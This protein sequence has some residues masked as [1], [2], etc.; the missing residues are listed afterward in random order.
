MAQLLNKIRIW[1]ERMLGEMMK[2]D[3]EGTGKSLCEGME[4]GGNG[5]TE[6]QREVCAFIVRNLLKIKELSGGQCESGNADK[7]MEEYVYCA[8]INMWIYE[9]R[10]V[11]CETENVITNAFGAMEKV[12][13][14]FGARTQCEECAYKIME[15]MNMGHMDMLGVIRAAMEVKEKI[16]A[17][18]KKKPEKPCPKQKNALSALVPSSDSDMGTTAHPQ[19]QQHQQTGEG[20]A[21]P[22]T[23][24]VTTT[25]TTTRPYQFLT[26]LLERWIIARGMNDVEDF[27]KLIWQDLRIAFDDMMNNVLEDANDEKTMCARVGPDGKQMLNRDNDS[28]E[29]CKMLMKISM[30]IDGWEQKF[31][32]KKRWHWVPR[33]REKKAKERRLQNYLRCLIGKVTM[34]GMFKTHCKL[35][36]VAPVIKSNMDEKRKEGK[37]KNRSGICDEIDN[38]SLGVG[39]KLIWEELDKWINGY[40]RQAN[41]AKGFREVEAGKSP[42][43]TIKGQGKRGCLTGKEKKERSET[44]EELGIVVTSG[45]K[46]NIAE[47]TVNWKKSA[48]GDMLKKVKQKED[49]RRKKMGCPDT[50]PS[51]FE[52]GEELTISEWFTHFFNEPT[53]D[54]D[55]KF[56]WD[57]YDGYKSVCETNSLGDGKFDPSK[58]G[59]FCKIMLKNVMMVTN[60]KNV[61]NPMDQNPACRGKHIPLCDLLKVWM[62]YMSTVCAPKE[63]ADYVF[64]AVE[65]LSQEWGKEDYVKCE[66]KG[67]VDLYRGNT[68]MLYEVHKLL[69]NIINSNMLGA[70]SKRKWCDESTRQYQTNLMESSTRARSD[71]GENNSIVSHNSEGTGMEDTIKKIKVRMEEEEE[72][73]K[74]VMEVVE[75]VVHQQ[76]QQQSQAVQPQGPPPPVPRAEEE[77]GDGKYKVQTVQEPQPPQQRELQPQAPSAPATPS[78]PLPAPAVP[79]VGADGPGGGPPAAPDD[80]PV[81]QV[82]NPAGPRVPGGLGAG[83]PEDPS[84]Q[85]TGPKLTS[86]STKNTEDLGK[87]EVAVG[88][89]SI[90]TTMD[91][92]KVTRTKDGPGR[93]GGEATPL[94]IPVAL[95]NKVDLLTPY[96]PTIPVAIAISVISYL[97]W[98]YFAVLGKS[99]KRHRRAH[100]VPGLPSSEEQLLDHVEQADGPH[101]YTLVKK[102]KQPRS[103]PTG[104]KSSKGCIGRRMIIDIHLE[105]LDE[106]QKGDTKLVQEDFFEILVQEFM[107]SE[108]IKEDFVPKEEHVPYADSGFREEDFLPKGQIFIVDIPKEDVPN[109]QVPCSDFGF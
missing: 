102:R 75:E 14:G 74:G 18:I 87:T 104:I 28:K 72:E 34:V 101:E 21:K 95:S 24:P 35:G 56:D 48:I 100:Q 66:Y 89:A 105:V 108:F 109:E 41:K 39:G 65:A 53:N 36:K 16:M 107:G 68:D 33:E 76:Q 57:K 1:I 52:E 98:K 31:N 83:S 58:H 43:H 25:S 20:V 51:G 97:L 12:K 8:V 7:E 5:M 26:K 62:Y 40:T 96:L 10:Q 4:Q 93:G 78:A 55:E 63:V 27:G 73:L 54:P 61:Y 22:V 49:Q 3:T 64:T 103:V 2:E 81:D 94:P 86:P 92:G 45:E 85:Q 37:I 30:W 38:A 29:L 32:S 46:D 50:N 17:L 80:S 79:G 77:R 70:L 9:Y 6:G 15:H 82:G 106:C 88:P 19:Q 90:T 69:Q 11:H 71:K 67:V 99:R 23:V 91:S 59:E 42:L 13:G 44:F 47:D 84:N 60:K